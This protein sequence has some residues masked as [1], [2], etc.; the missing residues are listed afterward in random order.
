MADLDQ[1]PRRQPKSRREESRQM[2]KRTKTQVH[3]GF[4]LVKL[5]SSRENGS[6]YSDSLTELEEEPAVIRQVISIA[7]VRWTSVW[8]A[9]PGPNL[10]RIWAP[11]GEGPQEK[12]MNLT[13]F[14]L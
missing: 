10:D 7:R 1:E 6:G 8:N 3:Q 5:V 11:M 14:E 2:Q 9:T 12:M 4:C 13:T